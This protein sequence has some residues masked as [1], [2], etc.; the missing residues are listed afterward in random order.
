[1]NLLNARP[2]V[3][4]AVLTAMS[5]GY[6]AADV[7]TQERTVVKFEGMLGRMMGLFGG[8]AARDGIVNTVS[9]KGDRKMTSNGDTGEIVDLAE[10]KIYRIDFDKKSYTV[11]TFEQLRKQLQEAQRK[12]QENARAT[13]QEKPTGDEPQMEVDFDL[14][15]TGQKRAIAGYDTREVVMTIT[16]REKGKTLEQNGGLVLS[17]DMWL[18]PQIA[19]LKE[20]MDFDMRY[21]KKLLAD[22][23]T[24]ENMQQMAAAMAMYPGMKDAMERMKK[25]HVNMSGSPLLT[26]MTFQ[27]VQ[28]AQQAAQAEK[29]SEERD[30]GGGGLMGG[31][32]RRMMKKKE[33][34]E[35]KAAATP[36]RATIFTSTT[37]VQSIATSVSGGDVSLPA[38]FKERN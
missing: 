2:I 25:E 23:W 22:T 4:M 21:A 38:G 14:K 16:V 7:K 20:Q 35:E 15:E 17:A 1:M 8:K 26:T 11:T 32:A 37:D 29:P 3:M 18:A 30:G 31:L 34:A 12:A 27:A 6:A 24:A 9:I 33:P 10:E 36:G 28:G 5:A 19:A 13:Q